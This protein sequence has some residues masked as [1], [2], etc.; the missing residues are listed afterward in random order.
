MCQN[1]R[2][3]LSY[4]VI[5]RREA[6]DSICHSAPDEIKW[7]LQKRGL[8]WLMELLACLRRYKQ[9]SACSSAL[10]SASSKLCMSRSSIH[11]LTCARSCSF[12]NLSASNATSSL[13]WW[14]CGC[15]HVCAR[16]EE[17]LFR[18]LSLFREACLWRPA[19]VHWQLELREGRAK[20][21]PLPQTGAPPDFRIE[22]SFLDWWIA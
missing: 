22:K 2:Y 14:S 21:L 19:L 3:W 1:P 7:V 5:E 9:M 11:G 8:E 6:Q 12:S 10:R 20:N 18:S 4:Q 16:D 13:L 15:T 17:C